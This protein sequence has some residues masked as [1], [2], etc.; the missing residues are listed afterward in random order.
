MKIATCRVCGG[1][2]FIAEDHEPEDEHRLRE[3]EAQGD[4]VDEVS[5][6]ELQHLEPCFCVETAESTMDLFG[7][8]G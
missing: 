8:K 4:T 7:G 5:R 6:D 1:I 2:V 3:L